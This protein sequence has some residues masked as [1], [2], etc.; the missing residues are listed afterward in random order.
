MSVAH[1][2]GGSPVRRRGAGGVAAPRQIADELRHQN[3]RFSAAVENMSHGLCM[4]DADERMIICNGNYISIFSLDAKIVRPGIAF[5]DILKHS[6]DIGVASQSAED[7]YAIRKPYI[8]RAQ[9]ST[10]EEILSDGR[11][12]SITH[13]PLASGGWVSIYEDI[14]EQRR[15]E[16]ELKEQHRRFDAALANMSQGLLM[17][18]AEGTLIVRNQRFLDL[19]KVT[20]D[21]FPLGMS[22]RALLEQ[23]VR[24]RIYPS[25][26]IDGEIA[27][28]RASLQA[29]EERSTDRSLADGRTLLVARRPLAGGGWVATFEDITER[30]RAEERMSHLAHYDTLTDLPNRSMFRERLDQAMAGDTPLAIFSL[31]LDR[32]KAVND[33][34]GHPAGDWLLKCVAE[35]LRHSLRSDTDVVARLGGDEFAILQFNPKGATDAEQL[36]KRIVAV[37]SQPFRDKGRDMHVGISLGIALYPGDGKDAD[38]LLKNADMALY[39]GK[40]EGRNVYRFFEPGMDALVRARL[41]LETDLETALKRREFVLEFQPITN[42]ASG[43][44]VGAEALMR[45]NS[46]TRGL[47]APD[48]FIAAAEDSGLIVP[49]GEWALKQACSVAAGWPP[50]MRIA[51]N[52]SAVQIRSADFARSVISALAVSGV[53]A[54]RLELEITETVLMD[55]SETVLKTLRQLRELGIRIAL[56]DFGT[57]YSSLGYLR[58]FPVDKIKI[59]RSFIHDIDN[60]DTAA[61]V[62]TIIGLGAELGITVTA[63]GVETEA[64]L[65][66]L[67]KA[68]CV[69][70]Q[71]FLIGMPSKAADMARLLKTRA[72]SRRA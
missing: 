20:P 16:Q 69:E 72:A 63:E 15:A 22:Q 28:T 49:L 31:D 51:V 61:I 6:V 67:R 68:G 17:Y 19:Y 60:K 48:D 33:T 50:G 39:S 10:Y 46:P 37:V 21:D 8:E 66:I 24:L 38:T 2:K 71:G 62:R 64:Q 45:W 47:V 27:N 70:A 14:T 43:K 34:W 42:I 53:P 7:L 12:V 18:D 25:M 11:I 29:G 40:S 52:V 32:F 13:R 36:A 30:R 54:S 55:E 23:M 26:D 65:D 57:G 56:D 58:R 41:A 9:A 4:F 35:R 1:V 5:L 3:E 59:D 44:I